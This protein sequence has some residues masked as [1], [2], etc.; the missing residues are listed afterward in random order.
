MSAR[1]TRAPA[2]TAA[3]RPEAPSGP[4][5]RDFASPAAGYTIEW[6][7]RPVYDFLFSLAKDD[8]SPEDLPEDGPDVADRGAPRWL[9]DGHHDLTA[10]ALE[11]VGH[12]LVAERMA[13][14]G[15][16]HRGP[17][18]RLERLDHV[19]RDDHEGSA[20][21][22]LESGREPGHGQA[23]GAAARGG[24]RTRI[25]SGRASGTARAPTRSS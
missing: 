16:D 23:P 20:F 17:A 22:R 2:A 18:G 9:V 5:V 4:P 14:D 12:E 25:A 21:D 15:A 11:R 8:D 19:G 3:R 1:P 13:I 10:D 6:D 7:V 24:R